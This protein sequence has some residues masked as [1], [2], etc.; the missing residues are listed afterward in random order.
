MGRK[1]GALSPFWGGE[2]GSPSSTITPGPM[3]TP[4]KVGSSSVQP[5]GHNIHGPKIRGCA[6]SL[7]RGELGPHLTMS[8]G[9]RPTSYQVASWSI[10]PFGYNRYRPNIW[11]LCPFGG[12]GHGSPSNAMWPGP[13]PTCTPSFIL[14]R[15]S[16]WPQYTNV[17][18]RQDRHTGQDNGPI[19]WGEPFYKRFA[20][21]IDENVMMA[22][23]IYT[24]KCQT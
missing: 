21:D 9:S 10:E 11:G 4:Y 13:M 14:T 6:P 3:P 12:R 16:V 17:T 1:L 20:N 18:D 23:M 8:L 2:A 5:F 19:A 22:M 7:R 24:I 15:P